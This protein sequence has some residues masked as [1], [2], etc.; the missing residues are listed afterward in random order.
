MSPS[1]TKRQEKAD[2]NILQSLGYTVLKPLGAGQFGHVYLIKTKYGNRAVKM[3]PKDNFK[4][5]EYNAAKAL[6]K[7]PCPYLTRFYGVQYVPDDELYIIELE[8][9]SAGDLTNVMTSQ[10]VMCPESKAKRLIKQILEGIAI[11]HDTNLIHRDLKPDNVL[12]H[13]ANPSDGPIPK[14]TDFGLAR[15]LMANELA[16]TECGTPYYMAPEIY[17]HHQPFNRKADIWSCGCMFYQ[18]ITGQLPFPAQ[19]AIQLIRMLG[20]PPKRLPTLSDEAWAFTMKLLTADSKKRPDAVDIL[21][22]PYLRDVQLDYSWINQSI[23]IHRRL[24]ELG[25]PQAAVSPHIFQ[26][27][28]IT[29]IDLLPA[30]ES[31]FEFHTQLFSA[32]ISTIRYSTR[33][34]YYPNS[35]ALCAWIL[36][37]LDNEKKGDKSIRYHLKDCAEEA[38]NF[39]TGGAFFDIREFAAKSP[40]LMKPTTFLLALALKHAPVHLPDAQC[41]ETIGKLTT[42]TGL[43]ALSPEF[44][45]PNKGPEYNCLLFGFLIFKF[46]RLI[47]TDE[48]IAFTVPSS[49]S[50]CV[51]SWGSQQSVDCITIKLSS[52]NLDK[53]ADRA[54]RLLNG[55]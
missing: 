24:Y 29:S 27:L 21:A 17:L 51:S 30:R 31:K 34:K 35:L 49:D 25:N 55:H 10:T 8:F 2:T 14:I 28:P 1:I 18:L 44:A 53:F 33:Q 41:R 32:L 22:D 19:T 54:R 43:P 45:I 48:T 36:E 39:I 52:E 7:E 15:V 16:Q 23:P 6:H 11:I 26:P 47:R 42:D 12:L 50:L 9:C 38:S 13:S 3:I 40:I 5:G 4:E 46:L 37:N 20:Y